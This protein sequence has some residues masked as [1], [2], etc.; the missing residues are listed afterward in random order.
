M[1]KIIHYR[2]DCIGCGLCAEY[3]PEL[4][5]I[6]KIDGK[7]LLKNSI[8][9]KNVYILE[10]NESDLKDTKLAA[11]DCPTRVIKIMK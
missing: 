6:S 2:D 7:A 3:S 8:L 1:T 5:E 11:R 10:I 9:K 4:W